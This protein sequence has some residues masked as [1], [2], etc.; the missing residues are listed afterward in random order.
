M[1]VREREREEATSPTS[2]S[3]RRRTRSLARC[4]RC[5]FSLSTDNKPEQRPTSIHLP[6]RSRARQ[7]V[8]YSEKSDRCSCYRPPRVGERALHQGQYLSDHRSL[9]LYFARFITPPPVCVSVCPRAYLRNCRLIVI[10]LFAHVNYGRGLVFFWRRCDTL[11][12]SRQAVSSQ[13]P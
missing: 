8:A 7:D 4:K 10:T 6:G 1:C 9:A 3:E 11:C 2:A 12:T 13:Q 5:W